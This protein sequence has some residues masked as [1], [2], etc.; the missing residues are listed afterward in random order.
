MPE[1]NY[2]QW[3]G[4]AASTVIAISMTMSSLLKLRIIN[5]FGATMMA[6]YGILFHAY[7]VLLLNTFIVSIDIYYL[8]KIFA[9]KD[10]F[11]ILEVRVENRYLIKFLEFH[12]K[13]VHKFFP[14]FSYDENKVSCSFLV[15]RNMAVAGVLVLKNKSETEAEILLDFVIPEYRDFKPG[16]FVFV[17]NKQLFAGKNIQKLYTQAH[18]KK[19]IKYL[20]KMQFVPCPD[21][22]EIWCKDLQS[23]KL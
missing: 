6:V 23:Y 20:K 11:K 18:T 12:A 2:I 7:P 4:Y 15:L 13:E 3:F 5:L 19:H 16:Y 10:Y 17:Q 14:N 21:N 8:Y 22:N 1:I 9:R